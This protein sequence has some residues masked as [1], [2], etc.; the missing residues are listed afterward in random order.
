MAARGH[1]RRVNNVDRA[2]LVEAF[3][4]N[5]ADYLVLADTLVIKRSTARSIVAT[6]LRTGRYTISFL[7]EERTTTRLIRR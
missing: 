4:N 5:Q 2:R 1:Y 6:Y 7:L 3:E